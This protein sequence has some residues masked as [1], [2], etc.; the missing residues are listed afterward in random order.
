MV[1]PFEPDARHC[2]DGTVCFEI[3]LNQHSATFRGKKNYNCENV[4]VEAMVGLLREFI[5][6]VYVVGRFQFTYICSINSEC[7][8]EIKYIFVLD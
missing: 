2:G 7:V 8:R 3:F 5:L 1:G 4:C 6:L